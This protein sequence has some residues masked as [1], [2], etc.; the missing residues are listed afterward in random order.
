MSDSRRLSREEIA[1][2][3]IGHTESTP[4]I[5]WFLT[6]FFLATITAV[7]LLQF[8]RDIAAIR[9]GKESGRT[10]PQCLD[11]VDC[12]PSRAEL[13]TLVTSEEGLL[14]AG[15][16]VNARMLGDIRGYETELKDSDA[17]MQWL[18]PR[19]QIPVTAWLKGGNE[20]AY[21]GRDGWLFYRKDI[22]SLTGR[23]F[24]DP[25]VLA[26][27]AAGGSELAAPPQPDPLAAIVDFRDQLARRGIAL[28]VMPA[29][30]ATTTWCR[31]SPRRACG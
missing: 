9:A 4:A 2:L 14:T 23:G 21:C 24:L 26:R 22:D 20:D 28:V 25:E 18:I 11:V 5:N 7:P 1:Q 27:R 10:V 29:P 16:R 19:M 6:L 30:Q 17:L 8:T 15:S 3:E 13:E 12:L 31:K